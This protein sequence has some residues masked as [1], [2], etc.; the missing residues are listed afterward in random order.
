MA[1]VNWSIAWAAI[2]D[3]NRFKVLILFN[4]KW[5]TG[6]KTA[7]VCLFIYDKKVFFVVVMPKVY[8]Y[9]IVPCDFLFWIKITFS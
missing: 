8:L 1:V 4:V 2:L 9:Q 5:A 7:K 6:K 3:N